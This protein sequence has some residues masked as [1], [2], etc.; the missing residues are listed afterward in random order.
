MEEIKKQIVIPIGNIVLDIW[1]FLSGYKGQDK[2]FP[3]PWRQIVIVLGYG[4]LWSYSAYA[5]LYSFNFV[6]AIIF[7]IQSF[8]VGAMSYAASDK[9]NEY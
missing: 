4:W 5:F 8:L 9:R 1:S 3:I 7:L 6:W 2:G